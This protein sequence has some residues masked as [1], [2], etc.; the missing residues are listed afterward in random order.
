MSTSPKSL[1]AGS[2]S[3]Y[4]CVVAPVCVSQQG[5]TNVQLQKSWLVSVRFL[6]GKRA[7]E[8]VHFRFFKR[9]DAL[10][11]KRDFVYPG[12]AAYSCVTLRECVGLMTFSGW[13]DSH[14]LGLC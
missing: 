14:E 10:R 8:I 5:G 12:S 7:G 3:A 4:A 1:P 9:A 13:C 11:C 6:T 2:T